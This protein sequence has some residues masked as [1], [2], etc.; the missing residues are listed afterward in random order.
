MSNYVKEMVD[1]KWS[2]KKDIKSLENALDNAK[3]H[4]CVV[5]DFIHE[6]CEHK[7]IHDYIDITPEKG[8]NIIYCEICE[9]TK[10]E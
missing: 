4:L 3:Q 10:P 5:T 1:I 9:L 7:W 6:Y 2:L 8:D